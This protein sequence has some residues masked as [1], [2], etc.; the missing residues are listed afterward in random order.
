[1]MV[2]TAGPVESW[3]ALQADPQAR[4]VDVRTRTEWAQVGLPVLDG[5]IL[6]SWQYEDGRVNP[7]FLD[8]LAAA[9]ITPGQRVFFLC[10]SGVRSLA[11]AHAAEQAGY[12]VC[13]NVANGFEGR[14]GQGGW[15]AEGLPWRR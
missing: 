14:G 10:R 13:V 8:E 4:L 15:M 12:E 1:M 5:L 9:G 7:A 2:T 6:A 11:A 3:A